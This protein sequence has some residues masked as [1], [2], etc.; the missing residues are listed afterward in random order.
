MTDHFAHVMRPQAV[1]LRAF[2]SNKTFANRI[3][4]SLDPDVWSKAAI[5]EA[6]EAWTQQLYS[7]YDLKGVQNTFATQ[8]VANLV[9]SLEETTT[10]C[11]FQPSGEE[12]SPWYH[13]VAFVNKASLSIIRTIQDMTKLKRLPKN[14]QLALRRR[15]QGHLADIVQDP[16]VDKAQLGEYHKDLSGDE[17][18]AEKRPSK[19]WVMV[20]K[21]QVDANHQRLC[22]D[23]RP[24][25]EK[26]WEELEEMPEYEQLGPLREMLNR[27]KEGRDLGAEANEIHAR[28]EI[29]HDNDNDDQEE[30]AQSPNGLDDEDAIGRNSISETD[31]G[32]YRPPYPIRLGTPRVKKRLRASFEDD[33]DNDEDE[34]R[35]SRKE[36]RISNGSQSIRHNA[37]PRE[38]PLQGQESDMDE[39]EVRPFT[40]R[41]SL[42]TDDVNKLNDLIVELEDEI[43]LRDTKLALKEDQCKSLAD[44]VKES[45]ERNA[46]QEELAALKLEVAS[47]DVRIHEL[48]TEADLL[49]NQTKSDKER[50]AS[51]DKRLASRDSQIASLQE[52]LE[53]LRRDNERLRNGNG[54]L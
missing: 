3:I 34:G 36:P 48:Q 44:E 51:R 12:G 28:V 50:I 32:E 22:R 10:M 53:V 21:A 7:G 9:S 40:I 43:A 11:S 6:I 54:R 33:N 42:E 49:R 17:T 26:G 19:V 38:T 37:R 47:R 25:V 35:N 20:G 23:P 14:V 4:G 18:S 30:S 31:D 29:E 1:P 8:V 5:D 24:E 45:N 46:S 52:N 15:G 2:L 16:I 13:A 39:I 41:P 27:E